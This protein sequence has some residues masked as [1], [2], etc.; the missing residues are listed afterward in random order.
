MI[1]TFVLAAVVVALVAA[2]IAT[3]VARNQS[4]SQE[5]ERQKQATGGTQDLIASTD[6][7]LRE[8]FQSLAREALSENRTVF[9]DLAAPIADTLKRVNLRLEEVERARLDAY[10]RLTEKIS[11]LSSTTDTLSRALRTPSVRGR[12]G[13]MQL[14]RVLELTGMLQHCDFEEQPTLY[15]D[16]GRL[17]PDAIIHLPGG[18]RIVVDVKTPLEAFLDAQEAADDQARTAKL[19]QHARQVLDHMDKLGSKAYWEPL[20]DSPEMVV[21]FLPGE[22]L[23]SAALQRDHKLIE[24]GFEH[25]VLL[26]SPITLI[27][28]LTTAAH[29]WRQEALAENYREVARLGKDF[30]ERLARFSEHFNDV[31]KKLDGAVRAYNDAVGSF[32]SRLLVSARRLKDLEVTAAPELLSPE[33]VDTLPRAI[34]QGGFIG[35]RG[36]SASTERDV[37]NN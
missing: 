17:R 19:E 12:W 22:M 20:G 29:S 34:K 6:E 3:L 7:R 14:R 10:A 26:A 2:A 37:S 35:I 32:E 23:F 30:Y 4:L 21:M 18:K 8:T 9:L 27:A 28:L 24:R 31:G 25:R 13:E 5:L 15:G 1:W 11:T 33:P 36:G 16:N